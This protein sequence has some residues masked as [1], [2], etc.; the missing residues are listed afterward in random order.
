MELQ[1]FQWCKLQIDQG[2]G[3]THITKSFYQPHSLF[4][5]VMPGTHGHA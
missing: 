3:T 4:T 5:S 1:Q 2:F